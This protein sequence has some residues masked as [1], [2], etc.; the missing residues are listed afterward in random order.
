MRKLLCL[1]VAAMMALSLCAGA[2]ADTVD[3]Y[4]FVSTEPVTL[5]A[6]ESQSN[7]DTYVFYLTSAM[8]YRDV[9]GEVI[10][11]VCDTMTASEDM[12]VYTYTLKDASYTDGTPI[13]AQD[14]VTYLLKRYLT[15]ENCTLFVGGEETYAN[16]ADTCEGIYAVDDKTFVVT[17]IE[18]VTNFSP[19]LEI[20][21]VN[22]DFVAEKGAGYGGTPADLQYSGPYVLTE[23]INGTRMS[24]VKNDGYLFADTLFPTK[25]VNLIVAADPSTA[26]SMFRSGDV[27]SIESVNAELYDILGGQNCYWFDAGNMQGLEFNTTGFTYSQGDGFVSRG[28]E[29]TALMKNMNFR[30]A[31]SWALDRQAIIEAVDPAAEAS[32]RYVH[33]QVMTDDGTAYVDAYPLEDAIPLEGDPEKANAYLAAALEELGYASV[34][35]LPALTYLGFDAS[36]HRMLAETV[37]S[38]WKNVLGLENIQINIQ[39]VQSAVMSMVFM[40]YDIYMQSLSLN[41]DDQLEMLAYWMT[42][43]SVSDPAGFQQSGAPSFMASMHANA[44]YDEMVTSLYTDF[45]DSYWPTLQAAEQALYDDLVYLPLCRGGN[46]YA[47]ADYVDGFNSCYIV[48]GYALAELTV[49]AH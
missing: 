41:K 25:N 39:P 35:D 47:V 3:T 2:C 26:Y 19:E 4:N 16:S 17:L 15:S 9:N 45:S 14:F 38:E 32:N 24:F 13:K 20:W 43:G 21:P 37:V 12:C 6:L 10:P 46:Y 18:P 36:A 27:D 30:L 5:N 34:K 33:S 23:W 7:L 29:V 42:G 28:E 11:E 40:D 44:A 31:L 1:A 49:N 22:A 48:D 8:L